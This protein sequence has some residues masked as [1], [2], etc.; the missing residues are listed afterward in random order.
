MA[1]HKLKSSDKVRPDVAGEL[2][3][4][5]GTQGTRWVGSSRVLSAV[6]KVAQDALKAHEFFI[7]SCKPF[8]ADFFW[9]SSLD[10]A[11]PC[12]TSQ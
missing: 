3:R 6:G 8:P 1:F 2:C 4:A 7:P 10:Q 11:A 5:L 12:Y 9:I